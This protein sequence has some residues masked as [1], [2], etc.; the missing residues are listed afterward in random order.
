MRK[1]HINY[2]HNKMSI[3]QNVSYFT[4]VRY[5]QIYLF[6]CSQLSKLYS[7]RQKELISDDVCQHTVEDLGECRSTICI[8]ASTPTSQNDNIPQSKCMLYNQNTFSILFRSQL[9]TGSYSA[10][11]FETT[12]KDVQRFVGLRC[13]S[14]KESPEQSL[15]FDIKVRSS[16]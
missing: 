3:N 7:G 11:V 10:M 13:Y 16:L 14:L 8:R 2:C 15:A 5:M 1:E 4:Y 6:I 9:T 12:T